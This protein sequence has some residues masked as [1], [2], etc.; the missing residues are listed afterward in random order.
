MCEAAG[1]GLQ[2]GEGVDVEDEGGG[3]PFLLSGVVADGG[4]DF[5]EALAAGG[6]DEHLVAVFTTDAGDGGFSRAENFD[7]FRGGFEHAAEFGGPGFGL[8]LAFAAD[9]DVGEGGEGRIA[10]GLAEGCFLFV[11]LG[12][13]LFG[14]EAD[15]VVVGVD[16]LDEDFAGA[17][18]TAGAAG[19]LGE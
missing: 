3:G 17:V 4:E 11:E 15:G 13:V 1:Q 18:A 5:A 6:F 7:A 8:V 9:E 2:E 14:G 16:G 19:G 12:V 10:H